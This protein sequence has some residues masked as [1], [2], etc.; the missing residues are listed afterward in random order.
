MDLLDDL[1]LS[2]FEIDQNHALRPVAGAKTPFYSSVFLG[3]GGINNM[4]TS[5]FCGALR[6]SAHSN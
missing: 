2:G 3:V 4:S 1:F 6:V 5:D